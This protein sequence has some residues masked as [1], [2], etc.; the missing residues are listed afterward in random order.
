MCPSSS[1]SS[2]P[3]ARI[4]DRMVAR[5]SC[6]AHRPEPAHRRGQH[7]RRPPRRRCPPWAARSAPAPASTA[8]VIGGAQPPR[9]ERA[10]RVG[11]LVL[12][13][14]I[15]EAEPAARARDPEERRVAFAERDRL[16]SRS[17]A[18]G[19][20]GIATCRA[21]G[22]A[23]RDRRAPAPGRGSA[24]A[25]ACRSA[26][27]RWAA[28]QARVPRR[29]PSTRASSRRAVAVTGAVEVGEDALGQAGRRIPARWRARS[30]RRTSRPPGCRSAPAAGAAGSGPRR[31]C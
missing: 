31:G 30:P 12:D 25:T 5:V 4:C 11:A 17:A 20:A 28:L 1:T 7:T 19:T 24:P 13:P 2:P 14:Q 26:R 21:V 27:T 16:L 8:R 3:K 29:N 23:P 18:A 10:G 22:A 9:L 15:V 6:A